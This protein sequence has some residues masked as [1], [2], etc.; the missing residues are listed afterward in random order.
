LGLHRTSPHSRE[1]Y[2][3]D[4]TQPRLEQ[5]PLIKRI[6]IRVS[7]D[8]TVM[9]IHVHEHCLKMATREDGTPWWTEF[10]QPTSDADKIEPAQVF[11]MLEKQLVDKPREF[12]LV[13]ARRTDC[14]GGTVTS[15]INLP[16]HSFYPTRKSLY[17]LCTQAGIKRV[18][19]YCGTSLFP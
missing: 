6:Q 2:L 7:S 10:P 3:D 1:I 8:G 15:S 12:L 4:T 9:T 5:S 16:A 18:I 13:D 17:E 19:F 14:T 11:E